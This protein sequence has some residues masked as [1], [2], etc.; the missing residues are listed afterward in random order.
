MKN[1]GTGQN[2]RQIFLLFYDNELSNK[3]YKDRA[4]Y[5]LYSTNP[6]PYV[7]WR[8][9]GSHPGLV[10]RYCTKFQAPACNS[11]HHTLLSLGTQQMNQMHATCKNVNVHF[12]RHLHS[13]LPV[14]NSQY[15]TTTLITPHTFPLGIYFSLFNF[16]SSCNIKYLGETVQENSQ[17]PLRFMLKEHLHFHNIIIV[18]IFKIPS[19]T[20]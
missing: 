3:K 1:F 9:E 16:W 5:N 8:G 7:T 6:L 10:L 11:A 12:T 4:V 17:I 13:P 2:T 20:V 18:N 19:K 14:L 15:K